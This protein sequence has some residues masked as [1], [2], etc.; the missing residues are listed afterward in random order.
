[1][2]RDPSVRPLGV[3]GEGERRRVLWPLGLLVAVAWAAALV[4]MLM[5]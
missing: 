3:S 1:M 2:R 4:L 5:P